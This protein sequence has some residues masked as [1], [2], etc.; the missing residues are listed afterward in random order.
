MAKERRRKLSRERQTEQ[1]RPNCTRKKRR[2]NTTRVD[3]HGVVDG[4]HGSGKMVK[5]MNEMKE[6]KKAKREK[7]KKETRKWKNRNK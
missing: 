2:Q 5:T 1:N 7:E 6:E 3:N 4:L